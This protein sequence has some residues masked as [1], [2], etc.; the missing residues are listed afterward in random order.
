MYYVKV[1]EVDGDRIVAACDKEL[2]GKSLSEGEIM[3]EVSR[4]FYGDRLADETTLLTELDSAT[5]ANL[6]G[7]R[8]IQT[9]VDNGII[10]AENVITIAGVKHAQIIS[11]Q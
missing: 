9:A 3:F 1:H 7:N 5:I 8:T 2:L 11:V 10:G 4:S 6:V